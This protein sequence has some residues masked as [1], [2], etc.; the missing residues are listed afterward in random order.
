[1]TINRRLDSIFPGFGVSVRNDSSY[2]QS[3]IALTTAG[4]STPVPIPATGVIL[5]TAAGRIRLKFY[6]GGGTTP[7]I[8]AISVTASDG[9]NT[10]LIPQSIFNLSGGQLL[11]STK[12]LDFEFDY[13]LDVATLSTGAGGTTGQLLPGGA[14]SFAV[15][16]TMTGTL[17]TGSLDAEIFPLI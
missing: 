16:Y 10:I 4:S 3:G 14:T 8:T 12:W 15:N 11:S 7:T 6:N 5:G 9:T 13:L 1:V 2:L 17:G